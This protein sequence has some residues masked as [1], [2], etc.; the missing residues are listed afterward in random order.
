M[1]CDVFHYAQDARDFIQLPPTMATPC[2]QLKPNARKAH[3][4]PNSM[5]GNRRHHPHLQSC[6]PKVKL[7]PSMATMIVACLSSSSYL[8]T[9]NMLLFQSYSAFHKHQTPQV[10]CFASYSVSF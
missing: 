7:Y 9:T 8:F 1:C 2:T 5:V 3:T 6:P 10:Y 4:T